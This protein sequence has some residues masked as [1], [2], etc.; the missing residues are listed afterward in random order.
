[1]TARHLP[2]PPRA[3][4]PAEWDAES[5]EDYDLRL[6]RRIEALLDAEN[7]YDEPSSRGLAGAEI[8]A[9]AIDEIV[10][11]NGGFIELA[12]EAGE[13]TDEACF[14]RAVDVA[15]DAIREHA[16]NVAA[17]RRYIETLTRKEFAND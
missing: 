11:V 9:D 15:L 12:L 7:V 10:N 14:K 3:P 4:V 2:L 13:L 6:V 17:T 1:M 8:V 5:R 16:E